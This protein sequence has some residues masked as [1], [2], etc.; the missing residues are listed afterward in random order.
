MTFVQEVTRQS[1]DNGML[2][3]QTASRFAKLLAR[4]FVEG[5]LA[6]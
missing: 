6:H 5:L 3:R 4:H 2:V 1:C